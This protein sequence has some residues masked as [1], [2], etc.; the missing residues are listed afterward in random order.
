MQHMQ[1][2]LVVVLQGVYGLCAVGLATYSVHSA[3]LVWQSRR[4]T[5]PPA[6][7]PPAQWPRVTIQLP[8]Y[9]ERH[10]V[11]RLIDACVQQDYPRHLLQVQVLDDSEDDTALLVDRRC[12]FWQGEGRQVE[13]VR[14]SS[15]GGFKAG[16][17][18]HALP[19]ATGEYIAIFDA[20]FQPPPDFLRRAIPH[21]FTPAGA[22]VGFVQGRWG[23]LNRDYSAVTRSQALALDGHFAIEQ[24]SRF[25]AGYMLGFNG[26]AGVWRR[27][28][29]EDTDVGGWQQ[30]TLCE[31]LDLSYRAQLAGWLPVYL[32]DLVAPAEIPPQVT[33]YKRQQFRW[34][35]GSVQT[36]RKL[37]R[38][39]WESRR[40]LIQ[41]V[42][43]LLHL[44]NYLIHPMLLTLLLI[45]PPI[46]LLGAS[47]LSPV[48]LIGLTSFGPPLLYAA[49]QVRLDRRNWWRRWA[50]L[51]LLTLLGMGVCL[52]N[53]R[54]VWQGL[55]SNGGEFQRTPKFRVER[56]GDGWRSSGYRL[57]IDRMMVGELLLM[58]Y[59]VFAA[60]LIAAREGWPSAP[61]MLLYAASFG[62]V[63][64]AG[65]WQD[66]PQKAKQNRPK[67]SAE[68]LTPCPPALPGQLLEVERQPERISERKEVEQ[69]G[70]LSKGQLPK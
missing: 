68:S 30:D 65:L 55:R 56:A 24:D 37:H 27:A 39:V 6:P 57:S 5:S 49:G 41:R 59:A 17:L 42:S 36:L 69:P 25:A 4:C 31:D 22:R 9:N 33:A 60:V 40:P 44:G 11:E 54:A 52:N 53:S 48:P 51:P 34:A 10:V 63:A 8:V 18:A 66:L 38:P 7:P 47:P 21:F 13:A 15:R 19:R 12:A 67:P 58:G 64:G 16:A 23:H 50:W 62:A 46:L 3:W 2:W 45:I 43:A 28:C 35:K 1:Q 14:R 32:N 20:D 61:F 29:I 26:S 70:F